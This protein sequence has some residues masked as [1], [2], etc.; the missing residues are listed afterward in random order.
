MEVS[1]GTSVPAPRISVNGEPRMALYGMGVYLDCR[2]QVNGLP[3]DGR[4]SC[5]ANRG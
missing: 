3:T 2:A 4:V 5:H 1:P